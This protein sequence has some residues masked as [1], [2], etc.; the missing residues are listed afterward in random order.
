MTAWMIDN[1]DPARLEIVRRAKDLGITGT[2]DQAAHDLKP[3]T[4]RDGREVGAHVVHAVDAV[5]TDGKKIVLII[6]ANDPGMGQ[7]ALPGGFLDPAKGGGV[8][9]AVKG[10]AREA[11]EEAGIDLAKAKA[12]PVG[13]RN[14]DRP[15][16]VRV[17]TNN[18]LEKNYGIKEGDIFMVSTQAVRFDVP[19]LSNVKLKYGDDA[20]DGGIKDIS[21]LR[22]G[23]LKV[24]IPDHLTMIKAALPECFPAHKTPPHRPQQ[25]PK[26]TLGG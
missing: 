4:L 20:V 10:A 25:N 11:A 2:P 17:A 26:R 13:T 9:S 7:F 19:G 8:E 22:D 6:R 15:F 18:G 21:K 12:T 24:G 5:I 3:I 1:D 14:M 23:T 16:D